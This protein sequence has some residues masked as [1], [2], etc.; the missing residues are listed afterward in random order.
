VATKEK[1]LALPE[2]ETIL[3]EFREKRESS[4]LLE[5]VRVADRGDTEALSRLR[6]LYA[7]A[8]ELAQA[9]SSWQYAVERE[10]LGDTQL[11]ITETFAVQANHLRKQLAGADPSPIE[12]LCVNRII[13]DHLHAL[14]SEQLLQ[15]KMNGSLALA[16]AD[17][18]Q[19]QAERAQ[20]RLLRS[21][22]TLAEVRKL[23]RPTLQVNIAERQVNVAGDV[24]TV[25]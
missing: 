15:H 10:I 11:G 23:L 1:S 19:K 2:A 21:V 3:A 24:H 12:A 9:L 8:P 16:Q 13:L 25:E 4:G 22:K 5:L 18:Y 17:F 7:A 6:V 20:R 14:K